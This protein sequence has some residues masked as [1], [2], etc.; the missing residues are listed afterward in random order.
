MEGIGPA[1]NPHPSLS[2][3]C[4]EKRDIA[5]IE[6]H[7]EGKSAYAIAKL[8]KVA[9]TSVARILAEATPKT[10]NWENGGNQEVSPHVIPMANTQPRPDTQ[11]DASSIEEIRVLAAGANVAHGKG[12]TE[13]DYHNIIV[14]MMGFGDTYMK[15]V[16]EP[17]IKKIAE[18]IGASVPSV[19]RG[20]ND[21]F[22]TENNKH[23]ALN[24]T[25]KEKRDIAIIEFHKE[26]KKPSEIQKM[27]RVKRDVIYDTIKELSENPESGKSDTPEVSPHVIPMA[28]TQARPETQV[29]AAPWFDEQM[30]RILVSARG[31]VIDIIADSKGVRKR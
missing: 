8:T 11:V 26:G 31:A 10:P 25:C 5:I 24:V 18:A 4:K 19:Q 16:F 28:N 13:A 12:N 22:G 6:F 2:Q 27:T 15:N 1:S 30:L 23:P 9:E 7:K 29:D 3:Q 17:D 20:Y 14:R 21:Y